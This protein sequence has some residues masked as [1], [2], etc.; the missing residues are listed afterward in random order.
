MKICPTCKIEKKLND[1]T[2][3]KSRKDG[4]CRQCKDCFYLSSKKHYY[5]YKVSKKYDDLKLNHKICTT[6]TN[7]LPLNNFKPS[8]KGKFGVNSVCKSCFNLNWSNTQSKTGLN[9]NY[10]S[11]RKKTN[12][13]FKLKVLLRLRIH[14]ALQREI[15]GGKVSKNHSSLELLGCDI[16]QYLNYLESKFL[17]EW[18]W[19]NHGL[20]WE[21]DHIK[22]C[23][24]FDLSDEK[25]QKECFHYTNTQPL[26]KT[27]QIA[28]SFGYK[29]YIGNR[30]KA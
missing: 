8:K 12:P 18:T 19:G 11:E 28:E 30:D 13:E 9:K 27:T 3:N 24:Q 10:R 2:K 20:I 23:H 6:C 5:T 21:I 7:E 29:N 22:P 17:P 1:F 16:K 4:L 15:N 26:F 14:D 25:Q